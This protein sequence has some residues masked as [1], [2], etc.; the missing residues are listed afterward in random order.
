[1][2]KYTTTNT[3]YNPQSNDLKARDLLRSISST[4]PSDVYGPTDSAFHYYYDMLYSY[5][6]SFYDVVDYPTNWDV[7]YLKD[8]LFR[9]GYIGIVNTDIGYIPLRC[10]FAGYNIYYKPTTLIVANPV[11]GSFERTIGEDGFLL[12][13]EYVNGRYHSL[14]ELVTHYAILLAQCDGSINVNLMN[15]RV[16]HVFYADSDAEAKTYQKIYDNISRGDPIVITKKGASAIANGD[17]VNDFLNVKASYIAGDIADLKRVIIC[18]FLTY[19]GVNNANTDKKERLITDEV[20]SNNG[21][22]ALNRS[23]WINT[24]NKC[25]EPVNALTGMNTRFELN[26]E[27]VKENSPLNQMAFDERTGDE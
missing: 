21:E 2:S 9:M 16:A 14:N 6:H 24:L 10:S 22:I 4:Q 3:T 19:I 12:F 7:S 17:R 5:I 25:L 1:M 11:L 8:T 23:H 27:V 26:K 15:S 13:F 20:N 18:E